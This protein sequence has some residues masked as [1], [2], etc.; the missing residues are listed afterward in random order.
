MMFAT[1]AASIKKG[2]RRIVS[3]WSNSHYISGY[4]RRINYVSFRAGNDKKRKKG[5][6]NGYSHFSQ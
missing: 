1:I 3:S 6:Y 5:F 2:W 4:N